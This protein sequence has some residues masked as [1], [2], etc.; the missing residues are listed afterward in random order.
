MAFRLP[1][2][3]CAMA[4]ISVVAGAFAGGAIAR[5]RFVLAAFLLALAPGVGLVPV[6]THIGGDML[7]ILHGPALLAGIGCAPAGTIAGACAGQRSAARTPP[8]P[9][10]AQA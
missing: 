3:I 8:R 2:A 6:A 4:A 1:L 7:T 5:R 9:A 10:T